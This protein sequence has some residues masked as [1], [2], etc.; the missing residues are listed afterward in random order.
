MSSH[1]AKLAEDSYSRVL[2]W[3]DRLRWA[4]WLRFNNGSAQLHAAYEAVDDVND[5]LEAIASAI[6]DGDGDEA[7]RL[8]EIS[9]QS[10][11]DHIQTLKG[12]L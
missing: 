12:L 1:V 6:E 8:I 7:L 3:I 9:K 5:C 2:A 10:I 11:S 4:F